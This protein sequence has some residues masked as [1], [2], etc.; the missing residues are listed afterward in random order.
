LQKPSSIL[1]R[2]IW[3]IK[4]LGEDTM[5]YYVLATLLLIASNYSLS[6]RDQSS[7]VSVSNGASL[8]MD[9]S[10]ENYKGTLEVDNLSTLT[11]QTIEFVGGIFKDADNESK[12]TAKVSPTTLFVDGN[13]VFRGDGR[14]MLK[15][16][17]IS[18]EGNRIEGE[19]LPKD[20][21]MIN[22]AGSSVL[23]S[24]LR[25]LDHNIQ[26]D[27]GII[28]LEEDLKFTDGKKINGSGTIL[29]NDRSLIFGAK[30]LKMDTSL[31]FDQ[32]N[33]IQLNANLYLSE[34]WTFSGPFNTIVGN[35]N[36]LVLEDNG[37]LVVEQG[38]SLLLSNIT[39]H[40]IAGNNIRCL[41][42]AATMTLHNTLWIQNGDVV[43][44]KGALT[45]VGSVEMRGPHAFAYQSEMT[46]TLVKNA[47]LSL[48][49]GCTFSYDPID[50]NRH[51]IAFE[52]ETARLEFNRAS[53][54]VTKGGMQLTK[55]TILFKDKAQFTAEGESGE[56]IFGDG[57][58]SGDFKMGFGDASRLEVIEGTFCYRNTQTSSLDMPS[59]NSIIRISGDAILQ[60]DNS[61]DLGPGRL[62]FFENAL[63]T[64]QTGVDVNGSVEFLQS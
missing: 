13:K 62:Q 39:I 43:F 25:S 34:T 35:G 7:T 61:I 2:G 48:D 31:Y 63:L 16:L 44:D 27:G 29:L 28:A 26:I 33:E 45:I 3:Y 64:R 24:L 52:D 5:R 19:I 51:C 37:N 54:Y 20:D 12:V 47:I 11:G 59:V 42:S 21:I 17:E 53:L 38:S 8:S 9:E 22:G 40:G 56:I 58:A 50:G 14:R 60:L 30:S 15:A 6:A 55:G 10:L 1:L 32:G 36:T 18:G 49:S 46:S 41:D 23:L 4:M 57:T